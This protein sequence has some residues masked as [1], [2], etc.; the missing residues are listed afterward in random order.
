[1]AG[2]D[3]TRE[4]LIS[5]ERTVGAL[6]GQVRDM[7]WELQRSKDQSIPE[8]FWRNLMGPGQVFMSAAVCNRRIRPNIKVV[9]HAAPHTR[10]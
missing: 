7:R 4:R 6:N 1:M 8:R 10:Q 2:R 5:L 9:N 3:L